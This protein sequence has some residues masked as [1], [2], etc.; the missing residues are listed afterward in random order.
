MFNIHTFRRKMKLENKM[1]SEKGRYLRME[2]RRD[3]T[4]LNP[5][6]IHFLTKYII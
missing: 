1:G 4:P 2:R 6:S 5:L 3:S